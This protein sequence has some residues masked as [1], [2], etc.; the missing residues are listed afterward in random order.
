MRNCGDIQESA[1]IKK[2]VSKTLSSNDSLASCTTLLK[3]QKT[4]SG[5]EKGKTTRKVLK[6]KFKTKG[7][8]QRKS[9]TGDIGEDL[10]LTISPRKHKR[11]GKLTKEHGN[12][13]KKNTKNG[14]KLHDIFHFEDF[15]ENKIDIPKRPASKNQS[16]TKRNPERKRGRKMELGLPSRRRRNKS[17]TKK[18]IFEEFVNIGK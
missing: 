18:K 9:M 17:A 10:T 5:K 7:R 16:A 14:M 1:E 15:D 2:T 3:T 4:K 11:N 8:T 6:I 13:D 12:D